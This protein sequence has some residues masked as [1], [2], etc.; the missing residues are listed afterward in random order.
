MC[1]KSSH[2]TS[3]TIKSY[4][5]QRTSPL[6]SSL[7]A[8][9]VVRWDEK[10]GDILTVVI[11][12]GNYFPWLFFSSFP[13]F[14]ILILLFIFALSLHFVGG[15]IERWM[16]SLI[17]QIVSDSVQRSNGLYWNMNFNIIIHLTSIILSVANYQCNN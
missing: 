3:S 7:C 4:I 13:S 15:R 6:S 12:Q 11:H 14:R 16:M 1:P 9:V 5:M 8:H 2:H 10:N 17:Y